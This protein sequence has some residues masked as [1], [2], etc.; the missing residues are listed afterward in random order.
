MTVVVW[1]PADRFA[2][3]EARAVCSSCSALGPPVECRRLEHFRPDLEA[4]VLAEQV[5]GFFKVAERRA[6]HGRMGTL[7][8]PCAVEAGVGP[9]GRLPGQLGCGLCLGIY[10]DHDM[11]WPSDLGGPLCRHCVAQ[12]DRAEGEV[13]GAIWREGDDDQDDDMAGVDQSGGAWTGEDGAL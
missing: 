11:R 4:F 3:P 5:A 13:E 1:I 12:L 9:L 8:K 7:C 6:G 10:A 2:L